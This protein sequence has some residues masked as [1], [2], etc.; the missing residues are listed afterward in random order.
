MG[1]IF[2]SILML[3]II[4]CPGCGPRTTT[5][6]NE[7]KSVTLRL[8]PSENNPR[9]SEGDFIQLKDGRLLFI[10]THFTGG[11]GDHAGA[12]L[13]GR[14]SDDGGKSWTKKDRIIVENE[15]GM[16]VMSVSLLRMRDGRIALFYLRKN[17]AEDCTPQVRFSSDEGQTWTDARQCIDVPGYYVMNNDRA[18]LLSSGRIVLPVS[19]HQ[20]PTMPRSNHGL[21]LC[22]YSDD[23]GESWISGE[24]AANPDSVMT[25]EPGVVELKDGRL[26]MFCRTDAGVQYVAYSADRGHS[27][28][29]LTAGNIKSPLSPASIER[30][31]FTGD[32]LLV[33]N[34]NYQPVG[35][36]QRRTPFNLAISR[37]EGKSWEKVKEIESDPNGWY[38]Y[39]AI[40]FV[41]EDVLLGHCAGNRKQNNGLAVTQITRL[42]REWIYADPLPAPQVRG[43]QD[44]SVEL[45]ATVPNAEIFYTTD[46]T[47]PDR[48]SRRYEGPFRIDKTTNLRM[49][50]FKR[51]FVPSAVVAATVG[52]DIL[53]EGQVVKE[54]NPGIRYSYF[55]GF[56][57]RVG[58]LAGLEPV[59]R[60]I[61]AKV[62]LEPRRVE[63]NFGLVFEGFIVIRREGQYTFYLQSNDGSALYLNDD[64]LID[65]DG[66]HGP[67]EMAATVGL[68]ERYH[69]IKLLYFQQGGGKVLKLSWKGPD[70]EIHE[71][72]PDE[73]VIDL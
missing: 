73:F 53:Q 58:D 37:D 15:G 52:A 26:M 21:I 64:L 24:Q 42:S 4:A 60:G 40:E 1:T 63:E 47:L 17:S 71:I 61:A 14:Y 48:Q 33:W 6:D 7:G 54:P 45:S 38:C 22:Y 35:D 62:S 5:L 55:E 19:M 44:G 59:Q 36:G 2:R 56:F 10:Y 9:N 32:L 68:K 50:S 51:G 57:T 39:T 31:P 16:N 29:P 49:R 67:V 8:E 12:H 43:D 3:V 18:V 28:S 34:N 30:I 66:G 69:K 65:N 72:P 11:S 46:G 41:G 25:Q 70:F 27:W 23:D 13:A 20:S